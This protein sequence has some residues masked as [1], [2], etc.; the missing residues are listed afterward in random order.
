VQ[1][2]QG[3]ARRTRSRWPRCSTSRR[4]PVCAVAITIHLQKRLFPC[5]TSGPT[6][7][8]RKACGRA[9]GRQGHGPQPASRIDIP[10]VRN[11]LAP[12]LQRAGEAG[13]KIVRSNTD[14]MLHHNRWSSTALQ[15]RR[16]RSNFVCPL[17]WHHAEDSI[18][19]LRTPA[20]R[21]AGGG[22]RRRP[23]AN[24]ARSCLRRHWK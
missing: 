22:V 23:R 17:D 11:G 24:T 10:L 6:T 18:A 15:H 7:R 4:D 14:P 16:H 9:G 20:A 5:P 13:V 1:S 21:P 12:A 19:L 2:D 3:V 8:S